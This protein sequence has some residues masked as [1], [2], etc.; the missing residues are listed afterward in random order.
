[1]T[2]MSTTKTSTNRGNQ[3]PHAGP[4]LRAREARESL[5]LAAFLA[6]KGVNEIAAEIGMGRHTV[7]RIMQTEA[8]KRRFRA[9]KEEALIGTIGLLHSWSNDFLRV[10]HEVAMDAK[11]HPQARTTASREAFAALAR[12]RETDFADRIDALEQANYRAAEEINT[13]AT[14]EIAE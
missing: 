8:F 6:G 2:T 14:A 10:L 12:F 3:K 1:M 7:N 4:P 13:Q 9:A 5:I 11:A